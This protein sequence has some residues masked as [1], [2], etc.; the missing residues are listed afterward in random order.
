MEQLPSCI[1]NKYSLQ[2]I[3]QESQK[4]VFLG[5]DIIDKSKVILKI[6][7]F[8]N[9]YDWSFYQQIENELLILKKLKH[10][11]IPKYLSSGQ[12]G[13][14]FYLVREYIEGYPLSCETKQYIESEIIVIAEQLF[15]ILAYLESQKVVH[16]DLKPDNIII[17]ENN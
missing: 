16:H 15:T 8:G 14:S 13:N 4:S 10:D 11:R 1:Q 17:N 12:I 5:T 7:Q 9:N 3:G 6:F 2:S